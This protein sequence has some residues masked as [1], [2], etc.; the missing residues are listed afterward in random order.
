[1]EMVGVGLFELGGKHYVVKVDK[2]SGYRFCSY[3]NKTAT[4]DVQVVLEKIFYKNGIPSRLRS[5]SGPQFCKGFTKWCSELGIRHEH[6]LR[7]A[8]C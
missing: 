6:R 3:L 5:D 4:I 8:H 7:Q 2:H 1:M